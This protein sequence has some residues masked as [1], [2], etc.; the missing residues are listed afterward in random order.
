MFPVR[1]DLGEE[2]D[3]DHVSAYMRPSYYVI[4]GRAHTS[5]VP[6]SATTELG[7]RQDGLLRG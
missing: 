3:A 6:Q 4:V 1:A 2:L 7:T 5:I